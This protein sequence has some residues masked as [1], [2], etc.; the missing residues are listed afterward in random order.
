MKIDK[1][2]EACTSKPS[3]NPDTLSQ[4]MS[5][6][7]DSPTYDSFREISL[8]PISCESLFGENSFFCQKQL[9]VEPLREKTVGPQT[10]SST[11]RLMSFA[12][13]LKAPISFPWLSSASPETTYLSKTKTDSLPFMESQDSLVKIGGFT[14][15]TTYKVSLTNDKELDTNQRYFAAN[16]LNMNSYMSKDLTDLPFEPQVLVNSLRAEQPSLQ[17]KSDTEESKVELI[18]FTHHQKPQCS[19]ESYLISSIENNLSS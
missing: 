18:N 13:L 3:Q 15:S 4:T 7:D 12:P 14:H 16:G 2:S 11:K 8:R 1:F 17:G 9:R 6:Q 19:A 10:Q 5:T